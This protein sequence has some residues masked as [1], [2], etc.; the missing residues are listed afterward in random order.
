MDTDKVYKGNL[1]EFKVNKKN[2]GKGGNGEVYEVKIL[3]G[4]QNDA[5]VVKML[6]LNRWWGER[7]A[8]RYQRF[9]KEIETVMKLQETIPGIMKILDFHCPRKIQS[10]DEVWY[11]MHKARKFNGIFADEKNDLKSKIK[12]L[13]KLSN[14]LCGLHDLEYSHR[15]IKIDNLLILDNELMLSDFGLVWNTEDINITGENERLGP[16]YIGPRELERRDINIKDFRPSDVYLFAKVVWMV[17]KNDTM[18]FRGSYTRGTKE[19]YLNALDYGITTFEPVQQ[20]LEQSTKMD[21]LAR[22]SIHECRR[23]LIEQLLTI[24]EPT[25]EITKAY[26]LNELKMEMVNNQQPDLIE[27]RDFDKIFAI[28]DQIIAVSHIVIEGA[29]ETISAD[30]IQKWRVNDR[31]FVFKN[32]SKDVLVHSYLCYPDYIKYSIDKN[33]I[34]LYVKAISR[35]EIHSG[36]RSY[37]ERKMAIWEGDGNIFLDEALVIRFK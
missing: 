9:Y 36:F 21:M 13:L 20:L 10:D 4:P 27:Y 34:R 24:N 7:K 18:G 30:S 3:K 37:K 15:D 11:L 2:I 35:E 16:Y 5:C 33:D 12:Y 25:S 26:K 29:D 1:Y 19:F 31:A 17:L 23:L 28:L 6:S 8:E 22:I 14:I 32:M